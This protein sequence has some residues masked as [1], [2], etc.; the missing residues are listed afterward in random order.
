MDV[1]ACCI[2]R[3]HSPPSQPTETTH[4]LTSASGSQ[5]GAATPT[6]DSQPSPVPPPGPQAAEE[7]PELQAILNDMIGTMVRPKE[8]NPFLTG[9]DKTP[10]TSRNP[11]PRSVGTSSRGQRSLSRGRTTNAFQVRKVR[12]GRNG[13]LLNGTLPPLLVPGQQV[14]QE[15]DEAQQLAAQG[16]NGENGQ[17]ERDGAESVRTGTSEA[18]TRMSTQTREELERQKYTVKLQT[19]EV[20]RPW[21]SQITHGD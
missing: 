15:E 3:P 11:S 16:E 12:I 13:Q 14:V 9:G 6:I 20:V 18:P 1:F 5:T 19:A 4:L 2:R 7:D 8:A 17:E 21:R 10:S